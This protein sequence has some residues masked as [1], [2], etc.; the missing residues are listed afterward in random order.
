MHEHGA[1][2]A[3]DETS[4][5]G[6]Y[7]DSRFLSYAGYGARL[8][9][10][11]EISEWMRRTLRECNCSLDEALKIV[12]DEATQLD[13]QVAPTGQVF[14]YAGFVKGAPVIETIATPQHAFMS[15]PMRP[16]P[17]SIL[18]R[19]GS[20]QFHRHRMVLGTADGIAQLAIGSGA[21]HLTKH[22]FSGIKKNVDRIGTG[23]GSARAVS[24]RLAAIVCGVGRKTETVSPESVCAFVQRDVTAETRSYDVN[25]KSA[26]DA[27]VP[28]ISC[29]MDIGSLVAAVLPVVTE[30]FAMIREAQAQGKPVPDFDGEK[31]NEALRQRA[32][33]FKRD[34]KF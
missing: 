6:N 8:D 28:T 7:E 27:R 17:T 21:P 3:R 9:P 1:A 10:M 4:L 18:P 14:L 5:A 26:N 15:I 29:G 34:T 24:S 2:T 32:A 22:M 12:A 31:M 23:S 16:G 25:G 30:E 11:F 19:D 33:D 20:Q 13:R